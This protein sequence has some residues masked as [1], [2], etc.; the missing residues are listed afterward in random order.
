[1]TTIQL[2]IDDALLTEID[3]VTQALAITRAEFMRQALAMALHRH[4]IK[5]LEQQHE[6]G[7]RRF[8]VAPGEFDGWESEQVWE[9]S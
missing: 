5:R 9:Q 2:A 3:R 8:P 7:Y 1:M 6:E 4:E